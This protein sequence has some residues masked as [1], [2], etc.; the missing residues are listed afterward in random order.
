MTRL[1]YRL[2]LPPESFGSQIA[3][4]SPDFHRLNSFRKIT[5]I[6]IEKTETLALFSL[7]IVHLFLRILVLIFP[8]S[9]VGFLF[10]F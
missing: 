8:T 6:K 2:K 9:S 5:P 3:T 7:Y 4:M 10:V 1:I